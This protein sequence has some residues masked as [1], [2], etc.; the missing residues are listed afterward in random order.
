MENG[1]AKWSRPLNVARKSLI[2]TKGGVQWSTP[3]VIIHSDAK[4]HSSFGLSLFL[5]SSSLA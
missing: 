1:G 4:L 2:P 3:P 5:L